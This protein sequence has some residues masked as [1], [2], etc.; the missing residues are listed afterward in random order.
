MAQKRLSMRKIK[1]L[2]RLRFEEKL[3][4]ERISC[5]LSVGEST[6]GDCLRRV[7]T[8]GLTYEEIKIF[9][10]EDLI[11][12]LYKPKG[13]TSK[14]SPKVDW[15]YMHRELRRKGVT[16][17][18]LWEEYK[19]ANLD[20]YQYSQ[21]C[22]HYRVYA[23]TTDY[24]FRNEHKG[25]EKLFVDYAGM[26]VS[27]TDP[28]TGVIREAQI[29]IATFGASNFTFAEASWSQKISEWIAS[30]QHAFQFFGGAP[31]ILVPDNL[32]SGVSRPCRYDPDINQT[33]Q[34]MAR[35][36]SC[37]VIPAR[38]RKP[39]DKAKVENAVLVVERWILAVLRNQQFFSL[40][41]LNEAI[42]R[43]LDKL[44]T[45]PYKKMQGSR[46]SHFIELDKPVLKKLPENFYEFADFKLAKVNIN[47]HVE[48][49]KHNYSVP[50][51]LIKKEVEI[52]ST[53]NT[54]EILHQGKRVA[55][56]PRSYREGGYTTIPEHMPT[57]HKEYIA[58][59]PERMARWAAQS[60]ENTK[61][62]AESIMASVRHPQQGFRS[63][64]G[65]IR[66]GKI[67]GQER[68][69]A[70]CA[71]AVT[72]NSPSYKTIKSLLKSQ[73]DRREV[74]PTD[75]FQKKLPLHPNIRGKEY[76]AINN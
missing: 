22:K 26:T 40:G 8:L 54:I 48:V 65:I 55:S 30:H 52:R 3:S 45:R 23:K 5:S 74:V 1:E 73:L 35:H 25:G 63:V 59:T 43:L 12:A 71:K 4:Y 31:E 7:S 42:K 13:I 27:I 60:G 58:W 16:L 76:Y 14:H 56:H 21:F 32:K 33:Y 37:V 75:V 51:T 57:S 67:Y 34:E 18:L 64:L 41:E 46:Y 68:L 20:G 62:I 66:L 70:A 10:E 50:Y 49:A 17:Q 61:K 2:L 36:Y 11:A 19:E 39:K 15:S 38:V 29:F 28:L 24:V 69:E 6:V 9:S 47:Y 44:N 72:I 53:V